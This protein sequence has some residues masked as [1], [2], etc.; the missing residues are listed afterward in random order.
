MDVQWMQNFLCLPQCDVRTS[1]TTMALKT[2]RSYNLDDLEGEDDL[3]HDYICPFCFDDFDIAT[4]CSH[5]EEEHFCESVSVACPV[6]SVKVGNDL[7]GHI[8]LHHGHLFK[9]QRRRKLRK[10][11]AAS[12]TTVSL[13]EE[14]FKPSAASEED[15][16]NGA[17][18]SLKQKPSLGTSWTAEQQ[19]QKL[20]EEALR[21]KFVQHLMLSTIFVETD[22]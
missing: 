4:L 1:G 10:A 18:S 17:S 15:S 5:I 16:L 3:R 14:D 2:N 8:T 12:S 22:L 20:E 9:M 21:A 13:L 19:Q 6:C 7:V 11:G